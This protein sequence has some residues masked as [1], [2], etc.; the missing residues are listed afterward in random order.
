ME[1]YQQ[2]SFFSVL[3]AVRFKDV[4][5]MT[6]NIALLGR[7]PMYCEIPFFFEFELFSVF[8]FALRYIF[9][10]WNLYFCFVL[11]VFVSFSGLPKGASTITKGLTC[12]LQFEIAKF[13]SYTFSKLYGTSQHRSLRRCMEKQIYFSKLIGMPQR[14][15]LHRCVDKQILFFKLSGTPQRGTLRCSI[16]LL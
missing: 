14:R 16:Y 5:L 4:E 6:L 11:M 8:L 3:R 7:Q 10:F 13:V 1:G 2:V 9:R 12:S 15:S